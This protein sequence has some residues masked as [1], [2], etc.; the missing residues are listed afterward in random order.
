[1]KRFTGE[2]TGGLFGNPAGLVFFSPSLGN[3]S[4]PNSAIVVDEVSVCTK[5]YDTYSFP[6][7][8]D[9]LPLYTHGGGL[10]GTLPDS[11][12]NSAVLFTD[13][14]RMREAQF[15]LGD[16]QADTAPTAVSSRALATLH[17]TWDPTLVSLLNNTTWHLYDGSLSSFILADNTAPI[18][19]GTTTNITLEP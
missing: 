10:T 8:V 2:V 12:L 6:V 3:G 18:P 13:F 7:P 19:A 11:V 9:P 14:Y 4:S 17:E 1:L 15:N 5:A 16:S